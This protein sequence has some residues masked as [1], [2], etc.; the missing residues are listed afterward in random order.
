MIIMQVYHLVLLSIW[1]CVYARNAAVMKE[2]PSV[3]IR[4]SKIIGG[5]AEDIE[6]VPYMLRIARLV[7]TSQTSTFCT[8]TLIGKSHMLT[9]RHC[10]RTR[11]V[12][13]PK[14]I[15]ILYGPV[16]KDQFRDRRRHGKK[17]HP[18]PKYKSPEE[19]PRIG[20]ADYDIAVVLLNAPI[21]LDAIRIAPKALNGVSGT[22]AGM[23]L[24]V[25]GFG[26]IL[27]NTPN[28]ISLRSSLFTV[29]SRA[30]CSVYGQ[31]YEFCVGT[32]TRHAPC[33]G[34]SGGPAFND[35][36]DVQYGVHNFGNNCGQ[37]TEA[38]FSFFVDLT[39]PD[40][41]DFVNK[42]ANE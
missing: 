31:P 36:E 21:F 9:A 28:G 14:D 35:Q 32:T 30:K 15:I 13:E 1:T 6:E 42:F 16:D 19:G 3:P 41:Y 8:G 5:I 39:H 38:P 12:K 25:A 33:N 18:H 17:I 29:L 24:R 20:V 2:T 23:A 27:P 40:I 34:D 4:D 11:F 10:T 26:R 22:T 7:R 37:K